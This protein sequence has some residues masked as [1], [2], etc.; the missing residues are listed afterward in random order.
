MSWPTASRYGI[1][2]AQG[3]GGPF[4]ASLT[5]M[6]T[7]PRDEHGPIRQFR[8]SGNR[9]WRVCERQRQD[10]DGRTSTI[11]VFDSS[12]TVRCVG[13]FPADWAALAPEAL[14]RLSWK[15]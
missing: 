2:N 6:N 9:N 5:A 7:R 13:H 1:G 8:D 10:L 3:P 11:L 14:E 4:G 15:T 12:V